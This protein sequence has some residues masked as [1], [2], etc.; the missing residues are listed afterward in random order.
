MHDDFKRR[1]NW[2]KA[3]TN[4]LEFYGVPAL[5]PKNIKIKNAELSV[6]L[7]FC[8]GVEH[9]SSEHGKGH[10][11]RVFENNVLEKDAWVEEWAARE[12]RR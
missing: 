1:L 8:L 4:R 2:G 10:K 9:G 5:L 3:A 12:R 7:L 6:F 11:L